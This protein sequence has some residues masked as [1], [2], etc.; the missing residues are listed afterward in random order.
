MRFAISR[1]RAKSSACLSRAVVHDGAVLDAVVTRRRDA[2]TALELPRKQLKPEVIV[3]DK[4]KPSG[5]A[6]R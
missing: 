3:T 5:A 6:M 2:E 1:R 4:L